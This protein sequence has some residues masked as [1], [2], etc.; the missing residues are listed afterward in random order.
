MIH[1]ENH[2]TSARMLHEV[3]VVA[4]DRPPEERER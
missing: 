3:A 4:L 1:R 2:L